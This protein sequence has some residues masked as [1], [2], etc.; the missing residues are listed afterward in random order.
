MFPGGFVFLSC[1]NSDNPF[2]YLLHVVSLL[3]ALDYLAN[4]L[5]GAGKGILFFYVEDS[6]TSSNF[7]LVLSQTDSDFFGLLSS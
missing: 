6:L 5:P 4:T 3:L 2:R 7:H 1:D